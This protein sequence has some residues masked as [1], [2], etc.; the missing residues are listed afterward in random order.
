MSV[1]SQKKKTWTACS[2]YIRLRDAIDYCKRMG[3]DI[4]RHYTQIE[5]LPVKCCT[6]FRIK[7]W[8]RMHAGHFFGRGIG[9][10]SGAYFDTRNISTQCPTCNAFQQGNMYPYKEFMLE[11]YGQQVID[12]LEIKHRSGHKWSEIELIALME[13][14][15]GEFK[16][17]KGE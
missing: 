15:K 12:E 17:M 7:S 14:F 13:Y 8:S 16:K 2:R 4:L 1:R 6:C 3:V 10:G 11:R 9:G 5:D